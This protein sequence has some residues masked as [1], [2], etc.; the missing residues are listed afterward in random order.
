MMA[1]LVEWRAVYN[2]SDREKRL[3]EG[4][5][6]LDKASHVILLHAVDIAQDV[7]GR[8]DTQYLVCD[9]RLEK[10]EERK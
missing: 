4:L 7:C 6:Q 1:L 9:W 8:K 10:K 2:K 5:V 3:V